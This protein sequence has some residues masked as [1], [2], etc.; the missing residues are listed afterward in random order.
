M[1][2]VDYQN[3]HQMLKKTV[4]TKSDTTAYRWFL[5]SEGTSESV[6][7]AEFYDQ[8]KQ[9]GKSLMALDVQKGDK[10]IILGNSCY[11]WVLSDMGT[12][13]SGAT[14]VGIYQS[15]LAED[16]KY[17]INHSDSVVIFAE[18][19][20]QLDKILKIKDEIPNIRKVILFNGATKD[21]WII[22]HDDFI[23]LGK[24]VTEKDY[25]KRVKEV[26]PQDVA[27][28]VYTSGTTGVPKGA[29]I[30]Q[31]NVMFTA[32]SVEGCADVHEGDEGFLFLPLAHIFAR[33]LTYASML[34][35]TTTNFARGMDS[36]VD[37]LEYD[38]EKATVHLLALQQPMAKDLR[39]ITASYKIAIDLERMSD[40][41]VNIAELV[42]KIEGEHVIPLEEIN[43]I[44][45]IT[46][47][48]ME[49]SMN[50]VERI[51]HY[52][53][54]P[55]EAPAVIDDVVPKNWPSKGLV[56]FRNISMKYI[57]DIPLVLR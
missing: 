24:N 40:F 51:H 13:C 2:I 14:T 36:I 7:W 29:V 17:I 22:S 50:A 37:D 38:V 39:L 46:Q 10:V 9:V 43:T 20:V 27:T 45:S 3:I 47:M 28:I 8:V 56:E 18:D 21:D 33:T 12:T 16:C 54:V 57:E 53:E 35:G 34:F 1:R 55:T 19:Q 25:Q 11:K 49:N 52:S 31:D 5:D 48:M 42:S 15:N 6:T 41:A 44:A 23:A 30:T 32:Q 4:D 26:T